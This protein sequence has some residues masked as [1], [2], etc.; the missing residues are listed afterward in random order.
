MQQRSDEADWCKR[1][2]WD[3]LQAATQTSLECE[4]KRQVALTAEAFAVGFFIGF[5]VGFFVGLDCN[6]NALG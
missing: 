1:S 2:A 3:T 5:F 4:S 6:R